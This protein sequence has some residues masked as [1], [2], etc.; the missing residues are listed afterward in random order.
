MKVF[1]AEGNCRKDANFMQGT[2]K[3]HPQ[4]GAIDAPHPAHDLVF[5]VQNCSPERER[6]IAQ[7]SEIFRNASALKESI[8][9]LKKK[10]DQ[11][12]SSEDAHLECQGMTDFLKNVK[13]TTDSSRGMFDQA[14]HAHKAYQQFVSAVKYSAPELGLEENVIARLED[15]V[16][17]V[18]GALTSTSVINFFAI[19]HLY[20]RTYYTGSMSKFVWKTIMDQFDFIEDKVKQSWSAYGSGL[21][22]QGLDV[23][24]LEEKFASMKEAF[25]SWKLAKKG[26]LAQKLCNVVNILVTSGFLKTDEQGFF[27]CGKFALFKAHCWDTQKE[28]G[29][30]I[31][32]CFDTFIFFVERGFAAFKNNDLTLLFYP[33]LQAKNVEKEYSSLIAA[34]SLL[35]AGRL[36]ELG[37]DFMDE[38]DFDVR[39]ERLISYLSDRAGVEKNPQAKGIL[40]NRLIALK[41]LRNSLMLAQKKAP[42]REKPYGAA[43]FGG[44]GV[45]KSHINSVLT[46]IILHANEFASQKE[47]IVTLNDTD[48]FQS[49][50][51]SHHTAVCLDD[52]ANTKADCYEK[53]PCAVIIDFLNNV[54]KAAL[55]PNVELKGNVMIKP[56][57]VTVTTNV[58]DLL[59]GNF[60]NEPVSVLRRFNYYLD[61]R[62]KDHAVDPTTGG[63]LDEAVTHLTADCW[64]INLERVVIERRKVQ[65]EGKT[66][67]VDGYRYEQVLKDAT[68]VEVLEY[69]IED[70]KK[71]Y[72][73]QKKFVKE[74]HDLYDSKLCEHSFPK[75][76]CRHCN[77]AIVPSEFLENQGSEEFFD[78]DA[79]YCDDFNDE[80]GIDP[81]AETE[82]V[83]VVSVSNVVSQWYKQ[84]KL[85]TV[86]AVKTTYSNMVSFLEAHKKEARI[87]ACAALGIPLVLLG[88]VSIGRMAVSALQL[89]GSE[90]KAPEPSE[91][92][93]E[94]HWKQAKPIAIPTS[95]NGITMTHKDLINMLKRSIGHA[96]LYPRGKETKRSCDIMPM[97]NNHWLLPAHMI[98]DDEDV[99]KIEV[100][101]TRR[102]TV[103]NNFTQTITRNHFVY[104]GSDYILV[105]FAKSVPN[106]D[107]SKLLIDD[108]DFALTSDMY[109][110]VVYKDGD[111]EASVYHVKSDTTCKRMYNCG[112]GQFEGI[113]YKMPIK[114]FKGL[115]M[116]PYVPKLSR[117]RILGFHLGGNPDTGFGVMGLLRRSD[118][119]RAKQHLRIICPTARVH[120]AGTFKTEKYGVD[121]TP[122]GEIPK[123][124]AVRFLQDSE[125]VQP[126]MEIY[127]AHTKGTAKFVSQVKKSPISDAVE[128]KMDLPREHGQPDSRRIWRHWNRDL[129]TM[130]HPKGNFQDDILIKAYDDL[131]RKFIGKLK[132]DPAKQKMI[133]PYAMDYVLSGADGVTS[134][135]RVD[136]NTSMGWPLNKKKKFFVEPTEKEVPG[137][138]EP[139]DFNDPK[140]MEEINRMED[141]F[142][143][144]ERVH[145]VHRGNLK[146]EPTKFTKDKIRVFAGSEFAFTCLVRKYFLPIVR[147]IQTHRLDFECAVGI[148]AHSKDWDKL[149]KHLTKRGGKRMV[150]GDYKAFDKSATGEINMLALDILISM[151]AYCGY[152]DRQLDIMY[153]IATEIAYPLYELDGVFVQMAGSNPSGHPLTVI[154]NNLINSLYER[155]VYYK[156]HEGEDVPNFDER[157]TAVNYGDDNIM[158]VS[159]E[160]DK[161]NHT[162][163]VN[164]LKDVGI[165]YTMADKES[166]SVP[167]ITKDEVSFLKRGF[168]W[169]DELQHY[170][171]P[172]EE[173]SIS[174]SLHNYMKRKGTDT[175]PEE[176]SAQAIKAANMEYFY[177]PRDVFERRRRELTEVAKVSG[178]EPFVGDLP[179]FDD[180]VD[181]FNGSDKKESMV[182]DVP[183]EFQC[184]EEYWPLTEDYT[185]HCIGTA[186]DVYHGWEHVAADLSVVFNVVAPIV[187]AWLD[188]KPRFGVPSAKWYILLSFFYTKAFVLFP[189]ASFTMYVTLSGPATGYRVIME[190]LPLISDWIHYPVA[191]R[192]TRYVLR[193]KGR[194]PPR[195]C[196]RTRSIA[197]PNARMLA[198]AA[199]RGKVEENRRRMVTGDGM[200]FYY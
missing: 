171:A 71:H 10:Q 65:R 19:L 39:L 139:V 66:R 191:K 94:N 49:E 164:V 140:F 9:L 75:K 61:V 104:V 142:A 148:N 2:A 109:G 34:Q 185:D 3:S 95:P 156:I 68:I 27:T 51:R 97:G 184:G 5:G 120:S 46:K 189:Y 193:K 62:L 111:G 179:T 59:A 162:A 192:K 45:G 151:A 190:K 100:Q 108:G 197:R 23:E 114:T 50:Y 152:T 57:L 141:I 127:G 63:L 76:E 195:S 119:V 8:A 38:Y 113:G 180:L 170:V 138:T 178:V 31:E 103:G 53:N 149:V 160:E 132:E 82:N 135:D 102:N 165:T 157:I 21:E 55:N 146:D 200:V 4:G 16:G 198:W 11:G 143:R 183:L 105:C 13:N 17:F 60:S 28:S 129:T 155:Y 44:S 117:A 74:I 96:T 188:L 85:E 199:S 106:A 174:K 37:T 47:N 153:G 176:I 99:V 67:H 115:C 12:S 166:E 77:T 93:E 58:K 125:G 118:I 136:L 48:K 78:A 1:V 177:H 79:A 41:K 36:T 182:P 147:V 92:D 107:F 20:V 154:L 158:D 91:F 145:V 123:K 150:A 159:E 24:S 18:A 172:L 175:L 30:F 87:A 81:F 90:E 43:I 122:N 130:A 88:T 167:F 6:I 169:S 163:M 101:T 186:H 25:D 86:K 32:M 73:S 35:E 64:Y 181:R 121:F 84:R 137:V 124:H 116:A 33:D 112:A 14:R 80:L 15:L 29:S 7:C 56:K 52:F 83:D 22:T 144:G 194:A 196:V 89:Q 72:K 70:S 98:K 187:I 131:S 42:L 126:T 128:E 134:V 168:R 69:L 161:F 110:S 173:D 54:T 26:E 40:G 133:H